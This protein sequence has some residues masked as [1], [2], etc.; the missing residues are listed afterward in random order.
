MDKAYQEISSHCLR[1]SW[2]AN[3]GNSPV[4]YGFNDEVAGGTKAP[5]PNS[6]TSEASSGKTSQVKADNDA[7]IFAAK[8]A[9]H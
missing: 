6:I 3:I 2:R 1:K 8:A 5:S 7:K 9:I 4:R